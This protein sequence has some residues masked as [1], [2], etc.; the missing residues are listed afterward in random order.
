MGPRNTNL[1]VGGDVPDRNRVVVNVFVYGQIWRLI[2]FGWL[3]YQNLKDRVT[4]H[5]SHLHSEWFCVS[6]GWLANLQE[7]ARRWRLSWWPP[8][9]SP[10]R[11]PPAPV[12]AP[13]AP[14]RVYESA[15]RSKWSPPESADTWERAEKGKNVNQI[16][17]TVNSLQFNCWTGRKEVSPPS[18]PP[19]KS[20]N[21]S[22]EGK[23]RQQKVISRTF[24][25][26]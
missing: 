2:D 8:P 9:G 22:R 5:I 1:V 16:K 18:R 4:C 17:L 12:W 19:S 3:K 25:W 26:F 10:S 13:A 7:I 6:Q 21:T 24:I 15:C 14:R 23:K 20:H 11:N